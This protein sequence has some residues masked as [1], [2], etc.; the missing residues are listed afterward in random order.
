MWVDVG[1]LEMYVLLLQ[2][3]VKALP[4]KNLFAF[5]H[6]SYNKRHKCHW[7]KILLVFFIKAC[8]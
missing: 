1:I 8:G 6:F 7:K 5:F 2:V 4:D 3:I